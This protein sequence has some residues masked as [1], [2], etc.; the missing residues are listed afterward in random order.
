MEAN[1]TMQ[2]DLNRCDFIGR[3]GADPEMR[4]TQSGDAV[5]TLRIAVS[6]T[7]TDKASGDRKE[8]TE[9]VPCVMWRKLAEVAQKYL[10]KGDRVYI[11]GQLKTRKWQ[12][13]NGQDRYTT[14]IQCRNM[15]MLGGDGARTHSQA[16][17]AHAGGN[18]RHS[19][20]PDSKAAHKASAA[21]QQ[22][23]PEFDDDLPF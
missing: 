7:W 18:P 12:D 13:S 6:E 22:P 9:W 4:Y 17:D 2:N 5:T 3:L 14:E 8:K 10:H 15:Q 11:S 1:L 19:H 21:A 16:A 20:T 23:A